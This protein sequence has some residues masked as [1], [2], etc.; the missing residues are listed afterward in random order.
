MRS[1]K[2]FDPI[3]WSFSIFHKDLET[4][5]EYFNC[6]QLKLSK[7]VGPQFKT[8]LVAVNEHEEEDDLFNFLDYYPL[9]NPRAH[10]VGGMDLQSTNRSQESKR[11]ILNN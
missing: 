5:K 1:L 7:I 4:M 11:W 6:Q 10:R 9:V 2:W 3:F 8:R